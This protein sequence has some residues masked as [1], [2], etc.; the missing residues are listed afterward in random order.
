MNI[1]AIKFLA[2]LSVSMFIISGCSKDSEEH[3]RI[4]VNNKTKANFLTSANSIKWKKQLIDSK[5]ANLDKYLIVCE[6]DPEWLLSRLQMNWKTRH[7]KVYLIGGKFSHSGGE[8]PVPTVRYSGSR[9]WA[10]DYLSP[11]LEEVT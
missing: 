11:D 2:L 9:D 8:A 1:S 6:E 7:D 3:P 4:Y 5:K 10:T